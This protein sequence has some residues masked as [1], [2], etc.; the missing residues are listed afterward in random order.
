[1]EKKEK[2]GEKEI[3]SWIYFPAHEFQACSKAARKAWVLS[4]VFHSKLSLGW[5]G[6]DTE[7]PEDEARF[8]LMLSTHANP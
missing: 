7:S 8:P 3:L 1:M 6:K 4:S 5:G 2:D